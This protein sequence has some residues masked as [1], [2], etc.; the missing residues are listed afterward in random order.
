MFLKGKFYLYAA[1]IHIGDS[2][3]FGHYL[4]IVRENPE[5]PWYM[6]DDTKIKD[7]TKNFDFNNLPTFNFILIYFSYLDK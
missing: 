6:L 2:I 7:L 5:D 1:I 3:D 4:A